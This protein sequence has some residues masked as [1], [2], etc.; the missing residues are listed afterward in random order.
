ML[1]EQ[2]LS[3][4]AVGTLAALQYKRQIGSN[5]DLYAT[6]QVTLSNDGGA[7][8]DNNS[9]TV[10]AEYVFG[11]LSTV[12]AEFVTGERGNAAKIGADY[13]LNQDYGI[14]GSYTYSSDLQKYDTLFNSQL[15]TGRSD[16]RS[17]MACIESGHYVQ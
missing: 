13:K 16:N 4:D 14:Y 11:E 5:L 10:G 9:L 2:R 1:D 3:G 7:Y 8:E 6:G 15:Y 17:A 12:M